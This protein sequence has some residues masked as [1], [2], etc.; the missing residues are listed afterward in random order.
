MTGA[1]YAD[2]V[3]YVTSI[4]DVPDNNVTYSRSATYAVR[5]SDGAQLWRSQIYSSGALTPVVG[6]GVVFTTSY[7]DLLA[8]RA[9]DGQRLWKFPASGVVGTVSAIQFG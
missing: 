6:S 3:V 8:L 7:G 9:A 5:A 1:T 4:F 2:G